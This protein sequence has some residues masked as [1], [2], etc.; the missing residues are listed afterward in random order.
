MEGVIDRHPLAGGYT[1]SRVIKGGWQLSDGHSEALSRDPVADMFAFVERGIDTFDCADIYTGVEELI[2]AFIAENRKR[3]SPWPVRVHTKYVP[4]YDTLGRLKKGDVETIIDRSL[5][6]LNQ[7]RLDMVQ[8][9]W[10]N[11]AVPGWVETAHWL[12]ELQQA[13]KIELL[14]LTNFNTEK[15]REL[16]DAGIDLATTQ[17]QFSLLDPRP[18]KALLGL[19]AERDMHLLCYGTLAGGFLS[20]RWLGQPEPADLSNRSLIKYKLMIDEAGGWAL[21][22]ALL[23]A[24]ETIAGRHGTSIATV[25]S[26][27][28]LDQPRVAAVIIGARNA[29]HLDRYADLF[30]ITLDERDREAIRAVR[31]QMQVPAE[32]VFDLERDKDGRHGGI[33][34]YNLNAD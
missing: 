16:A 33:M 27:W 23:Q 21:F 25:A 34:K 20:E 7:E 22:Q 32:D 18:E 11:Y 28:V 30:R 14:S 29:A 12:K 13:G 6:R 10:W 5:A 9:H 3:Q 24:L 17:V 2:G 4:D 1:I 19:C 8:F 15:T 31:S 26:R